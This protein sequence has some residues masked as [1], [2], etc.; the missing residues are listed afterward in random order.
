MSSGLY[1]GVLSYSIGPGGDFDMGD[2]MLPSDSDLTLSF[3]LDVQHTLKVEIP[4]GGEKVQLVPA[5]GWQ[6]WL[7]AGR[8]PERLFRDQTF[9]ISASSRF[10]MYL[11]C[12]VAFPPYCFI[13]N[14]ESIRMAVLDVSVSLPNGL[15]DTA[16]QPVQ[17]RQLDIG[18]ANAQQFQP[19]FY[20]DRAPGILHFEISQQ[21][22]DYMLRSGEANTWSGNVT[23]IWDS[24]VG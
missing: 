12:E 11:E 6:N 9:H 15:T 2:I 22:V 10:K 3:A 16:G 19:G 18:E 1:T 7:Q 4:P 24:E 14:K 13:R 21:Q 5:G 20:M 23:V 8:Q 17:R